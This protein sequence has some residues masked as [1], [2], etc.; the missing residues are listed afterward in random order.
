MDDEDPPFPLRDA[1]PTRAMRRVALGL[2]QAIVA[3]DPDPAASRARA[4][5][6][7]GRHWAWLAPLVLRI[8]FEFGDRHG[9][10]PVDTLQSRILRERAFI[11]AF[12]GPQP[13]PRIRAWLPLHPRMAPARVPGIGAALPAL[14]TLADLADWLE[15]SGEALDWLADPDGWRAPPAPSPVEHYRYHWQ[16]KR[17][18]RPRL[19]EAPKPRL[20]A[21]QRRILHGLLDHVP[22]HPAAVGCVRG[23]SVIDNAAAHAGQRLLV[24]L[25][26]QDFFAGIR[27]S[28]IHALFRS[29]G[30]PRA[31]ARY[32]TGLTT[33]RSP[34]HILRA[35]PQGEFASLDERFGQRRRA[36]RFSERH[37]PQGAPTSPALAN[38]CAYR[39]DLRL[40]GAAAECGARYSRYVDDLAFSGAFDAAHGQRMLRMIE[41]IVREEGFTPNGRKSGVFT[42][43][44]RQQLTGIVVN[45]H[46]NLPRRDYD[47][48]KAIL[49][50]CQRHGAASQN[51][52]GHRDFRAH[53]HGRIAWAHA[54]NPA[55]GD[56]LWAMFARIDWD[57]A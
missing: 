36:T 30:Y 45:R 2:A 51:R 52:D 5:N 21:L 46:P 17:D 6:A 10:L 15:I 26:L 35:L 23:R 32:L 22:T 4:E 49:S 3:G 28:R 20:R 27:A 44:A 29:L 43:A 57:R 40:A 56:T 18:G 1:P 39:L 31:V 7:L 42:G 50:N 14:D 34:P 11:D 38:L 25:D 24:K 16:P 12:C 13:P 8:H 54:L 55:R 19:I 9:A 41:A 53:L 47:R 48:L 33:H 37:L